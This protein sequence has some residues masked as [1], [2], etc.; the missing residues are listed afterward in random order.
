VIGH[1][2]NLAARL[3]GQARAGELLVDVATWEALE[4]GQEKFDLTDLWL[5]GL[6]RPVPAMSYFP[7][8]Q[9]K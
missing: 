8:P 3:E 5:K 2:A 9:P 4:H 7:V 6:T 1:Q